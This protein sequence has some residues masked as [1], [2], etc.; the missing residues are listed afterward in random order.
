MDITHKDSQDSKQELKEQ[1]PSDSDVIEKEDDY[2]IMPKLPQLN[3][4]MRIPL[5][6]FVEFGISKKKRLQTRSIARFFPVSESKTRLRVLHIPLQL[7][8]YK[9]TALS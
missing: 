8:I 4:R 5:V 9:S 6:R 2:E 1:H 7:R 3:E